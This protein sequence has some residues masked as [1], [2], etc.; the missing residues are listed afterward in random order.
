MN[1]S[2]E[3]SEVRLGKAFLGIGLQKPALVLFS[4]VPL[5]HSHKP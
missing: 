1:L 4:A 5:G 2:L 3:Q